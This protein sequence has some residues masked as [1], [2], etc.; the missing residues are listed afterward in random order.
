MENLNLVVAS[1]N[2]SIVHTNTVNNIY[3]VVWCE[4]N[5]YTKATVQQVN[6]LPNDIYKVSTMPGEVLSRSNYIL[7]LQYQYDGM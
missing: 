6:K 3:S 4:D 7:A 1:E 2:Y 5:H